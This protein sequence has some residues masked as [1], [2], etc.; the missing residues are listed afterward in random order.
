V[1]IL[2][3]YF[4]ITLTAT[5]AII[6]RTITIIVIARRMLG[7]LLRVLLVIKRINMLIIINITRIVVIQI[8]AFFS[9]VGFIYAK[10]HFL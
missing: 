2:C 10:D 3:F 1:H 6:I 4:D 5:I 9:F 8:R 7:L